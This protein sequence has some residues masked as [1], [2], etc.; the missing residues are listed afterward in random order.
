MQDRKM[1]TTSFSTQSR[2]GPSSRAGI[3]KEAI[4]RYIAEIR[5]ERLDDTNAVWM[6]FTSGPAGQFLLHLAC[7]VCSQPLQRV[8]RDKLYVRCESNV[9]D[10]LFDVPRIDQSPFDVVDLVNNHDIN[11]DERSIARLQCLCGEIHRLA[12]D[13]ETFHFRSNREIDIETRLD[14]PHYFAAPKPN[15]LVG[16]GHDTESGNPG[17]QPLKQLPQTLEKRGV[18]LAPSDYG[19]RLNTRKQRGK[20][21]EKGR[22]T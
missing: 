11:R 20:Y 16:G 6:K 7:D 17:R 1:P 22:N 2:K 13:G 9:G 19:N 3:A 4:Y 8:T 12:F 10:G 18:H 15:T 5:E 21:E 14:D